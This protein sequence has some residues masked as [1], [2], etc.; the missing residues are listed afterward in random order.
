MKRTMPFYSG[1][2]DETGLIDHMENFMK[3]HE[4]GSKNDNIEVDFNTMEIIMHF[5]RRGKEVDVFIPYYEIKPEI[6]HY[7]GTYPNNKTPEEDYMGLDSNIKAE[8]LNVIYTADYDFH[9]RPIKSNSDLNDE[10]IP[11]GDEIFSIVDDTIQSVLD[12]KIMEPKARVAYLIN[13]DETEKLL[14]KG[15]LNKETIS[16]TGDSA[17]EVYYGKEEPTKFL[18]DTTIDHD[19]KMIKGLDENSKALGEEGRKTITFIEYNNQATSNIEGLVQEHESLNTK[20]EKK[21][22]F[23]SPS[24]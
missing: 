14:E 24:I 1:Q 5:E 20:N 13:P 19:K 6:E 21:I 15:V 2:D 8:E 10:E 4:H 7:L 17:M 11:Y 23:D 3:N 18:V 12:E 22:K 16:F 9:N